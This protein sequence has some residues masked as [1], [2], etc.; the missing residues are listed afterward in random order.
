MKL[1]TKMALTGLL[2]ACSFGAYAIPANSLEVSAD[3]TTDTTW[4]LAD[5]PVILRAPITVKNG[6][7]LTIE[8]GVVVCSFQAEGQ[9]SQTQNGGLVI[10]RGSQ[11]F[12]LGTK[13]A[14]VIMT[15]AD[16]VAT[17]T[18]TAG[19]TT[20]SEVIIIDPGPDN[21]PGTADDD[22]I[23]RTIVTDFSDMGDP[24]TGTR[25]ASALEWRNLTVMGNALI[26]SYSFDNKATSGS[27][28][29]GNP[30]TPG[31]DVGNGRTWGER[32]MEGLT[33]LANDPFYG[34]TNDDDDSG[35]IQYT[36]IRYGGR[37]VGT[38]NELNGISLGAI[39]RETDINHIEIFGNVDDGIEIWGG[40][41]F[42]K[43]F[44]ITDIGDDSLD[45]DQGWRGGAQFGLIVQG[46][47][48][49]T[50]QGSGFGDNCIEGDGAEDSDAQPRTTVAL[51][52]M[53]VY[54][55]PVSGDG[56]VAY[57]DNAR[58]QIRRSIF[59]NGAEHL[60]RH[61][62]TDSDGGEGYGFN[63]TQSWASTWAGASSLVSADPLAAGTEP[64][65]PL[66]P[67]TLAG[68]YGGSLQQTSGT[69]GG[70]LNE[71]RDCVIELTA[72]IYDYEA[73]GFGNPNGSDDTVAGVAR[74]QV[75]SAAMSN[76]INSTVGGES[77]GTYTGSPVGPSTFGAAV[78]ISGGR[79]A[80]PY[81]S[82]DPRPQ[83]EAITS[84]DSALDISL[85]SE[86]FCPFKWVGAFSPDNNW[87]DEW[88]ALD[89]YGLTPAGYVCKEPAS[90]S[91]EL[92]VT[93]VSFVA[94]SNL[95]YIIECSTD[96]RDWTAIET[97]E[98]RSGLVTIASE[99]TVDENKIYRVVVQ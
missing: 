42:I 24:L 30:I 57:R 29:F 67:F 22:T 3:I 93:Q 32:Q 69:G 87:L 21:I 72:D 8:A 55:Q 71:I 27:D 53:T 52:N 23:T 26:S 39:G 40:T 38:G 48:L 66:A 47:S 63:G 85:P 98:G 65:N 84:L 18:G 44:A 43:H 61:D 59:V 7:S 45:F 58:I 81:T 41:V 54:G 11:I 19:V 51:R 35:T 75:L 86:T 68:L 37:V 74:G 99:I 56:Y 60:I 96:G 90:V 64:N 34:G 20:S 50:G 1:T 14:P 88:S 89:S 28:G 80:V 95:C 6:A 10:N 79:T 49:T 91:V 97:I 9:V 25:R 31:T 82:I 36:S 94:D 92:A 77:V 62:E 83:N 5:S 46:Y 33:N 2:A 78:A 13:G 16:D 12:S 73:G 76:V 17:W 4:T 70:R 15:S